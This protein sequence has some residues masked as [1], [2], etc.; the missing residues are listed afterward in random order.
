LKP[1]FRKLT[2]A[3][4]TVAAFAPAHASLLT[5]QDVGFTTTWSNNVLTLE[6]DAG[7]HSGDWSGAKALGA[8]SL[9]DIGTF[10]SVKVT[11]AP[12]GADAWTITS[13]ELTA[14][15]CTGGAGSKSDSTSLCLT[16]APIA[17]SDNMVFTFTFT[18]A[19][20]LTQPHLKVNFLDSAN[21]KVGDLLSQSIQS[22]AVVITPPGSGTTTGNEN[23]SGQVPEPKT[24]ALVFA[25][26]ALMGAVIRKKRR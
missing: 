24:I 3:L 21:N 10:T 8:L 17:L 2:L 16:G 15:G 22:S 12:K 20:I 23:P 19:P 5:Y 4:A 13:R 9:K 14:N 7:Q 26:L 11:A 18:G 1:I 25:G 6:I